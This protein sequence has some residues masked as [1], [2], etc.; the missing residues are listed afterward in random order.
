MVKISN[1]FDVM[2]AD[3]R[4]LYLFARFLDEPLKFDISIPF[5]TNLV[6]EIANS[7][8]Y[9]V[10]LLGSTKESNDNATKRLSIQYPNMIM[11]D[12]FSGGSITEIEYDHIIEHVYKNKP[13]IICIGVSTPKK[14]RF[15]FY[16]KGKVDTK[17]IIPYGGMIDGLAGTVKLT[18]L[19]LK[20]MGFATLF[21]LF[22]E[23]GRL[24]V[25]TLETVYESFIKVIQ[26]LLLEV[27]L[28]LNKEFSLKIF[29]LIHFKTNSYVWNIWINY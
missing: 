8:G 7:R 3:G 23:S 26:R 22:Q 18:P 1:S 13:D 21:R 10:W 17:I 29:I 4:F 12:G 20:K 25:I 24:G 16:A 19:I 28:K 2:V 6:F 5:L 9:S 11:Y 14:E 27:K 15:A